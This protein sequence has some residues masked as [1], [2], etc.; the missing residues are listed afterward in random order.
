[1]QRV[2]NNKR[3][4]FLNLF[5][6]APK[7]SATAKVSIMHRLSG[8]LLFLS[9]PLLLFLLERSLTNPDFYS[10]L[11]GIT[12]SPLV[13]IIYILLIWAFLHHLCAGVRFLFLDV[14]RGVDIKTA[15]NTARIVF[16]VSLLITLVLGVL[17]W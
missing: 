2:I 1:M 7:M 6:L 13:K 17:I 14:H 9:V 15:K 12:S 10:V 11:Y 8:V 4:K 5:I 3:P 16:L